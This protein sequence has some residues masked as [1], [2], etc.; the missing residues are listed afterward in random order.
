MTPL[1]PRPERQKSL[2][3]KSI[4]CLDI[5][6]VDYVAILICHSYPN[7]DP[8]G[9][10]ILLLN[11]VMKKNNAFDTNLEPSLIMGCMKFIEPM[12]TSL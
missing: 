5:N 12:I 10:L 8:Y 7:K 1:Q 11:P 6:L 9:A 3:A 2:G 4:G